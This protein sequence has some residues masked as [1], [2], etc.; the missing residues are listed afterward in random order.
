MVSLS[1]VS[2]TEALPGFFTRSRKAH[3]KSCRDSQPGREPGLGRG[4]TRAG[5]PA[6]FEPAGRRTGRTAHRRM[7][8]GLHGQSSEPIKATAAL[9]KVALGQ[10]AEAM[11][12]DWIT[13]TANVEYRADTLGLDEDRIA[14]AC[15]RR[16]SRWKLAMVRCPTSSWRERAAR[17]GLTASWDDCLLRAGKFEID[18]GKLQTPG[19]IYQ[20]SG[21][22]SPGRVLDFKLV[23]RWRP[24]IQH[25]RHRQPASCSRQHDSQTLRPRSNHEGRLRLSFRGHDLF[26][27]DP[28]FFGSNPFCFEL[29]RR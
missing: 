8:S 9:E 6:A 25:Y 7:A 23:T 19:G 10:I 26:S 17:C 24:R 1:V 29:R 21:T 3:G 20:L 22:A 4:R 27:S 14:V 18:Q 11:H 13:G 5:P 2:A 16:L 12:D 15:R 28:A